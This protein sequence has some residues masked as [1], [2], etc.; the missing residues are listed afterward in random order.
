MVEIANNDLKRTNCEISLKHGEK[1]MLKVKKIL[2]RKDGKEKEALEALK[3]SLQ[4]KERENMAKY[5][6]YKIPI[7]IVESCLKIFE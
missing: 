7:G 5:P 3:K 1:I 6:K 2:N 4:S